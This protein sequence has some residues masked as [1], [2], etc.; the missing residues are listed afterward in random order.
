MLHAHLD[1]GLNGVARAGWHDSDM[2][3]GIDCSGNL[4]DKA[5]RTKYPPPWN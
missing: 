2:D 5:R 4:S 3:T 1:L